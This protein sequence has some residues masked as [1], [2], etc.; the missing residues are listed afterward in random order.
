MW[1]MRDFFI[2]LMVHFRLALSCIPTCWWNRGLGERARM[3]VQ[4]RDSKSFLSCITFS[5]DRQWMTCQPRL[6]RCFPSLPSSSRVRKCAS[7]QVQFLQ[8][9]KPCAGALQGNLLEKLWFIIPVSINTTWH[10]VAQ[11]CTADRS[12]TAD[13]LPCSLLWLN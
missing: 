10:G 7:F 8:W 12:A 9:S 11:G 2:P 13:L 1:R 6:R 4:S 5:V 3:N